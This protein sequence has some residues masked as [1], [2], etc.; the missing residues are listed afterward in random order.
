L[1]R[2]VRVT[3]LAEADVEKAQDAY[4]SRELGLGNRF[5]EQV[6]STLIRIGQNPFQYQVIAGTREH[7]RAPVHQFRFGIWYRVE[8]DESVVVA[9]LAHRQDLSLARRRAL[10]SVEPT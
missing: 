5:L 2:P 4:E 3:P 10:R 9:C 7:R 8:P 6:R 1:S